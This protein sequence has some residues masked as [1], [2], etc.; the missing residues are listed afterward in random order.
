MVKIGRNVNKFFR[1]ILDGFDNSRMAMS[2]GINSY[3]GGK[4]QKAVAI[5][6]P[7]KNSLPVIHDK[8]VTSWVGR[9]DHLLITFNK[10]LCLWSG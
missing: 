7:Y 4:I 1:L 5:H 2:G 3:S 6:I 9:R 8:R 10:T